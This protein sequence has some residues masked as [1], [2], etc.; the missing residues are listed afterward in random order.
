MS[1]SR[2]KFYYT[3]YSLIKWN[4]SEDKKKKRVFYRTFFRNCTITPKLVGLNLKI[5]NGMNY[6]TITITKDMIGQKLGEFSPTRKRPI[7]KKK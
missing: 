2:W 4:P 5:Y 1:R 6:V 3:P 7:F